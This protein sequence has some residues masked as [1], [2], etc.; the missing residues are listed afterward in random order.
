MSNE[1]NNK[2]QVEKMK[3]VPGPKIIIT[4]GPA[5]GKGTQCGFIVKELDVV[6]L[7]SGE[8][9]RAEVE[10]GTPDGLK[11]KEYM[12]S[13][14]LVPDDLIIAIV[15]R[16]VIQPDCLERGF[17]LDG[18]PRTAAQ[19][20]ALI[21]AGVQCDVFLQID[22]DD[23][24]IIQRVAGRR[25]DPETGNIYHM[26]Y[27]PP[28]KEIEHRLVQRDDDTEENIRRRLV[29]YHNNLA[30]IIENFVHCTVKVDSNNK[31][32]HQIWGEFKNGMQRYIVMGDPT[33]VI[34]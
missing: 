2:S 24:E 15:S 28:P 25:M 5:S 4:G 12:N 14:Q 27:V 30:D 9:L 20:E 16:R 6:H 21:E 18:F 1:T 11:A 29:A 26:K 7:S 22:V 17:V 10:A 8:M 3:K 33:K 32:P 13:G 31:D 34:K 19:V 23:E